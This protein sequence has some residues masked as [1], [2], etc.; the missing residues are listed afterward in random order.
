MRLVTIVKSLSAIIQHGLGKM[1]DLFKGM[2]LQLQEKKGMLCQFI[3]F[4]ACLHGMKT[5]WPSHA[6]CIAVLFLY[7]VHSYIF[8][9][10][11]TEIVNSIWGFSGIDKN[12]IFQVRLVSCFSTIH[13]LIFNWYTI[14]KNAVNC[15]GVMCQMLYKNGKIYTIIL[16][17]GLTS[18]LL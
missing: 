13:T 18:A 8:G 6:Q 9:A 2:I 17:G 16:R 3:S 1:V 10:L 12:S 5:L 15:S 7:T 14:K 11:C 4:S